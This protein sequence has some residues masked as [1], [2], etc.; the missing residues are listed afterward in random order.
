LLHV[1]PVLIFRNSVFCPHCIYVCL[2]GSL[3]KE[4][5]FLY[6]VLTYRLL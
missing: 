3:N 1:P 2:R 4:R 6:T 5:L